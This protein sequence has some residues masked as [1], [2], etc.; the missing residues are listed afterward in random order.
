M[1]LTYT[2]VV[3]IISSIH[4]HINT[5]TH[6]YTHSQ[7]VHLVSMLHSLILNPSLQ[8]QSQAEKII[9]MAGFMSSW[10]IAD[11]KGLRWDYSLWHRCNWFAVHLWTTSTTKFKLVSHFINLSNL[12]IWAG[13]SGWNLPV[14]CCLL[15]LLRMTP[16]R[17][18]HRG[19]LPRL[20]CVSDRTA[21]PSLIICLP[22][23]SS[24]DHRKTVLLL[25]GAD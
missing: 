20:S 7:L 9:I 24:S 16:P 25:L 12:D 6:T 10:H 22:Q 4:E 3:C 17:W 15:Q 18:H 19:F 14:L 1:L 8:Y 2:P 13:F 23:W 21:L 11:C 5:E